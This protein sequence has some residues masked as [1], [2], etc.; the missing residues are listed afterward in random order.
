MTEQ[1][2]AALDEFGFEFVALG[3]PGAPTPGRI[4]DRLSGIACDLEHAIRTGDGQALVAA[5]ATVR[6]LR[7]ALDVWDFE[8]RP[9]G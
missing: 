5:V 6:R 4:A 9:A 7:L 2:K 1:W 8:M 3:Q